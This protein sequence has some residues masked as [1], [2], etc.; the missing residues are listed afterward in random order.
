MKSYDQI[1]DLKHYMRTLYESI[2]SFNENII[3]VPSWIQFN[4]PLNGK[5]KKQPVFIVDI[6]EMI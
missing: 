2:I 4:I 1:K 3:S 5:V 6:T